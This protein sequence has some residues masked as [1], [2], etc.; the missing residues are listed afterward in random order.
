MAITDAGA[1][2]AYDLMAAALATQLLA[3]GGP[4]EYLAAL[5][6]LGSDASGMLDAADALDELNAG[7]SSAA[8]ASQGAVGKL[9]VTFTG[10]AASNTRHAFGQ[11]DGWANQQAGLLSAAGDKL[12]AMG[13]ANQAAR[14]SMAEIGQALVAN[15]LARNA[16]LAAA[17]T[18]M[19]AG[20]AGA[21]VALEAAH[22]GLS[23]A[24]TQTQATYSAAIAANSTLTP[25]TT[26]PAIANGGAGGLGPISND[27][28]GAPFGSGNT[29]I[30]SGGSPTAGS[31]PTLPGG[32]NPVGGGGL[33]SSPVGNPTA[34]AGGGS[35]TNPIAPSAPGPPTAGTPVAPAGNPLPS[36][37]SLP[38]LPGGGAGDGAGTNVA[39]TSPTLA[40]LAGGAG[41]I[42]P[43]GMVSGGFGSVSGSSTGFRLPTRWSARTAATSSALAEEEADEM[44]PLAQPAPK[45]AIAPES[46]RRRDRKTTDRSAVVVPGGHGGAAD[47]EQP[48]IVGVIEY[49]EED[50]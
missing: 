19:G 44:S 30:P 6:L 14:A 21:L 42:V 15:D 49:A 48:S 22:V 3:L 27:I 25:L 29:P 8:A 24:A 28:G 32:G 2:T 50:A 4:A 37:P 31:S 36:L 10:R 34:P 45:G 35:P 13:L 26:A 41:S 16:A 9:M 47:L 7:V 17:P 46:T 43:I 38:G 18:N 23:L 5:I 40:A 1:G 11:L 12:R 20:A 39:G 33:P